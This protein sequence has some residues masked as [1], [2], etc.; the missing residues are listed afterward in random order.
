[1]KSYYVYRAFGSL[2]SCSSPGEKAVANAENLSSGS[3]MLSKCFRS[4]IS[5][6]AML[7]ML[8]FVVLYI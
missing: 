1:M 8:L 3:V 7:L 4:F 5:F 2:A 6:G